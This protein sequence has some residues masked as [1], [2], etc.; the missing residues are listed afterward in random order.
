MDHLSVE[1]VARRLGLHPAHVRRLV[2]GGELPGEKVG[3]RW[4]VRE[5]VLSSR[6]RLQPS[7]GRP[8]SPGM[9]WAVLD[10]VG[11]GLK[12]DLEP[13]WGSVSVDRRV[14]H[15]LRR[16]VA[17]A[18]PA[19]R[20]ASWLRRR[21]R[22]ERLAVHPGVL[23]RLAI[24]PRL[25]QGGEAAAVVA[26]IGVGAGIGDDLVFYV[27]ES[28]F[29]GV[30]RDYR[31]WPDPDGVLF[32]VIPDEVSDDVRPGPGRV[33]PVVALVDL[34]GSPDAR[35]RHHAAA[36]LESALQRVSPGRDQP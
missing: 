36:V 5:D 9:A 11:A 24:D 16:I 21:A 35:Q 2:R 34:L 20:W 25:H 10:A 6:K 19:L 32:M 17:D 28:D 18:P 1:D 29:D 23:E 3:G 33:D 27:D 7:A 30:I 22:P 14:R 4:L 13:R 31:A 15:R 8:L 12:G 26:E